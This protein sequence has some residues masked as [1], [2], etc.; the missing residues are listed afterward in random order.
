MPKILN[1]VGTLTISL[2]VNYVNQERALNTICK[3]RF[4]ALSSLKTNS[5]PYEKKNVETPKEKPA[6]IP[7]KNVIPVWNSAKVINLPINSKHI[8]YHGEMYLG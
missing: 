6:I 3:N 1:R 8:E 5:M 4:L 2:L 7:V